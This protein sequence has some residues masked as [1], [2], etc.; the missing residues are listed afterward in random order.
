MNT[1][2]QFLITAAMGGLTVATDAA[3]HL[4]ARRAQDYAP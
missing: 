4:F 2:R 3:F 1:R